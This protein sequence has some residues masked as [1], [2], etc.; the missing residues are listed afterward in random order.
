MF[1]ALRQRVNEKTKNGNRDRSGANK[2]PFKDP[3]K[4]SIKALPPK[5]PSWSAQ[6][7]K[8]PEEYAFA[9][10]L[11]GGTRYAKLI[12]APINVLLPDSDMMKCRPCTR[13]PRCSEL[14]RRCSKRFLLSEQSNTI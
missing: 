8:S 14:P 13:Q 6:E 1:V 4:W 10:S 9:S 12:G 11:Q 5:N 3:Q 2:G 7:F